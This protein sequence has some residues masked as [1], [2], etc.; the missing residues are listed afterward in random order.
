MIVIIIVIIIITIIE[1]I[2]ARYYPKIVIKKSRK[3][4]FYKLIQLVRLQLHSN[5]VNKSDNRNG[6][7][8][9]Y[10]HNYEIH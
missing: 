8:I 7:G 1:C 3:Q 10:Y 2:P 4:N 6:R 5:A 9:N